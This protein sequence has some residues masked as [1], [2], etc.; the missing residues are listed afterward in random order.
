MGKSPQARSLEYLRNQGW[1]LV[2]TVEQYNSFSKQRKDL[3]GFADVLC[4]GPERG[5]LYVQVT[6]GSNVSTRLKKIRTETFDAAEAVLL[7]GAR[8]EIHGWRKIVEKRGSKRRVWAP[9]IIEVDL[10]TLHDIKSFAPVSEAM[11][12]VFNG[13]RQGNRES[14]HF[15]YGIAFYESYCIGEDGEQWYRARI[16]RK[17]SFIEVFPVSKDSDT[18]PIETDLCRQLANDLAEKV[19]LDQKHGIITVSPSYFNLGGFLVKRIP[20]REDEENKS[21]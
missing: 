15:D 21:S 3:F 2:Q 5:H 8:I 9:R 16:L 11:E 4:A 13:V 12:L 7:S 18:A 6:S 20:G 1:P 17:C 19:K 10:H 14:L